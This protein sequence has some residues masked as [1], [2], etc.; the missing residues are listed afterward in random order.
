M[1]QAGIVHG[2][3]VVRGDERGTDTE[4]LESAR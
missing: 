3:A 2:S 1:T 4:F